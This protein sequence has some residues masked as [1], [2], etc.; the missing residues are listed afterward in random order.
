VSEAE[1]LLNVVEQP[2]ALPD[3]FHLN[4]RWARANNQL[5]LSLNVNWSICMKS[6]KRSRDSLIKETS[7]SFSNMN[8]TLKIPN[9]MS[10][11]RRE[12]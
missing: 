6:I 3:W 2:I 4:Q 12:K 1:E 10:C 11:S 8:I 9:L 7:L 5:T